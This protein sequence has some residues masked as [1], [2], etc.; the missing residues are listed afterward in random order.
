ML[1]ELFLWEFVLSELI[2]TGVYVVF[3]FIY[4]GVYVVQV[5]FGVS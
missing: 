5:D 1:S 3:E 2:L 4:V